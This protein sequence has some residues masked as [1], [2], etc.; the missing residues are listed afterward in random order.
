MLLELEEVPERRDRRV[1]KLGE[2]RWAGG[3][4][5]GLEGLEGRVAS[6]ES[7]CVRA[8]RR[9]GVLEVAAAVVPP[10]ALGGSLGDGV[11]EANG[12]RERDDERAREAEA[13]AAG[14]LVLGEGLV[15]VAEECAQ[16]LLREESAVRRKSACG[17]GVA[18][19]PRKEEGVT[20]EETV[21]DT[22][23][24]R[25]AESGVREAVGGPA[26][27]HGLE[28]D[29]GRVLLWR[30]LLP[31]AGVLARHLHLVVRQTVLELQ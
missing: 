17:L 25:Q 10:E 13:A 18:S 28:P 7:G 15:E 12:S 24:G 6:L 11:D 31:V 20:D 4:L 26:V 19:S 21:D 9:E 14:L 3:V 5:G 27:H 8:H 29:D 16:P 1:R 22:V 2:R 23:G 30:G